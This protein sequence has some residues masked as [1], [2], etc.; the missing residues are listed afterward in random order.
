MQMLVRAAGAQTQPEEGQQ[1][2]G[3]PQPK[4]PAEAG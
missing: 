4:P 2:S 1:V 3:Q